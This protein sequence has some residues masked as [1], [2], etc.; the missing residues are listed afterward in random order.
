MALE[1]ALS[2]LRSVQHSYRDVRCEYR[3]GVQAV[4]DQT[5]AAREWFEPLV[6]AAARPALKYAYMLVQDL[7]IAEEILQEA[8]TRAWG[9]AATPS[10]PVE[11]RRWL[12]RIISNLARD[13]HRRQKRL[14][15]IPR[16]TTS[17]L[18]PVSQWERRVLHA[19]LTRR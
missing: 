6:Y 3:E 14:S 19:T 7:D 13:Y 11:F 5:S 17:V 2:G 8:F 15:A 12:Y 16:G 10:N 18:D 4:A 1:S 9:A